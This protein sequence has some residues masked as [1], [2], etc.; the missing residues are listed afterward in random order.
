MFVRKNHPAVLFQHFL[1]TIWHVWNSKQK[2]DSSVGD[3]EPILR[4]PLKTFT[5]RSQFS[6]LANDLINN[7]FNHSQNE[8]TAATE[9]GKFCFVAVLISQNFVRIIIS[10]PKWSHHKHVPCILTYHAII[11]YTTLPKCI[12]PTPPTEWFL[13]TARRKPKPTI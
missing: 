12:H 1:A 2:L 11:Y 4:S 8:A 3:S 13:K 6:F 7:K 10:L 9:Q 5:Q